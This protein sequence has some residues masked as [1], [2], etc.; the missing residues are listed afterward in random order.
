MWSR[1]LSFNIKN[2]ITFD[3]TTSHYIAL[4]CIQF[5]SIDISQTKKWK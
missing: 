3:N 5:N 2:I 1:V 4:Q